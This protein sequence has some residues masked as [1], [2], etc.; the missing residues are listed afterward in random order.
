MFVIYKDTLF[1]DKD[2]GIEWLKSI[3]KNVPDPEMQEYIKIFEFGE[4]FQKE[5]INN[6]SVNL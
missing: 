1:K 2:H 3:N 6:S 5:V 4:K